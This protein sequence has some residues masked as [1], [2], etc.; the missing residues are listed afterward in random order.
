VPV[1]GAFVQFFAPHP[2]DVELFCGGALLDHAAKGDVI[3][4]VGVTRGGRGTVLESMQ[5]APLEA[6]RTR[7]AEECYRHLPQTQLIWMDLPDQNVR[8]TP[9]NLGRVSRMIAEFQSDLIYLPESTAGRSK[10]LHTDHLQTGQMV[11]QAAAL[12][13]RPIS[14]RYYHTQEEFWNCF[15]DIG[16]F[17]RQMRRLLR[18]HRSQYRATARPAWLLYR[19]EWILRSY[20][21]R[22]GRRIGCKFAEAFREVTLAPET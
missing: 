16:P 17:R 12:Q 4:V 1:V 5:G 7:E 13:G 22:C 19:L 8:S 15:I 21:R 2:D 9:E 3:Q 14:M 11:E 6:I 10:Y 20:H 18:N